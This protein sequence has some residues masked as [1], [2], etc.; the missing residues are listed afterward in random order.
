MTTITKESVANFQRDMYPY[1]SFS[2]TTRSSDGTSAYR[3]L[4]L[5]LKTANSEWLVKQTC[6]ARKLSQRPLHY[7]YNVYSH[8][9]VCSTEQLTRYWVRQCSSRVRCCW[10]RAPTNQYSNFLTCVLFLYIS[11]I[12]SQSLAQYSRCFSS[13]M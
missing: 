3:E 13:V 4:V 11:D 5:V 12:A 8:E 2:Y 9:Y 1:R 10:S 6:R 7:F